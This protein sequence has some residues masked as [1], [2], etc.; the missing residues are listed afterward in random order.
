MIHYKEGRY[1]DDINLYPVMSSYLVID[2]IIII[3][4]DVLVT[5]LTFDNLKDIV[6]Q[7]VERCIQ[8]PRCFDIVKLV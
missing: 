1:P 5:R 7:S 3:F 2:S 8:C 4:L 6:I